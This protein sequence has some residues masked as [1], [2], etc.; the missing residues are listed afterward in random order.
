MPRKLIRMRQRLSTV[1]PAFFVFPHIY[2]T[3]SNS[4]TFIIIIAILTLFLLL[5]APALFLTN[6]ALM[7]IGIASIISSIAISVHIQQHHKAVQ[8]LNI[9]KTTIDEIKAH[10]VSQLGMFVGYSTTF[11]ALFFLILFSLD[12]SILSVILPIVI[13]AAGIYSTIQSTELKSTINERINKIID[14]EEKSLQ[15]AEQPDEAQTKDSVQDNNNKEIPPN[16]EIVLD[17]KEQL[18]EA[19]AEVTV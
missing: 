16:N 13:G 5:S 17:K 1:S 14:N 9:K 12:V 11:S 6:I 15:K 10:D 7:N 19:K 2:A 8:K 4:L 3:N 18:A